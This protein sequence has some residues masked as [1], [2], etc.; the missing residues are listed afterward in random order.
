VS[1]HPLVSGSAA[2]VGSCGLCLLILLLSLSV[3]S[4]IMQSLLSFLLWRS[5]HVDWR[6]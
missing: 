4:Y 5:H 3:I 2:V 6:D 1:G